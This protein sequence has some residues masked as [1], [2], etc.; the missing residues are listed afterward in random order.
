LELVKKYSEE[1]LVAS[2]QS[3]NKQA[4]AYLYDNYAQ[5]LGSVIYKMIGERE[6]TQDILQEVF[7]KIWS[8]FSNYENTKAGLFTWML[9]LTK[10]HTIDVLRSKN[11]KQRKKISGNE[12][13]VYNVMDNDAVTERF[14]S[15]GLHKLV[16]NLKPEHRIL[17]E[18]VYF[19]G[20]TQDE[21]AKELNIPL[22]TVK[23]RIR[24]A[25]IELR[26]ANTSII[27]S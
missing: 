17:I 9:N 22:G 21:I 14:D 2:L 10:N 1:E 26:K 11:Y 12:N 5:A 6:L 3:G 8:N 24:S 19:N 23:T 18:L 15:I 20:Y 16:K 4:F 27:T 13:Y 7:I 25:L